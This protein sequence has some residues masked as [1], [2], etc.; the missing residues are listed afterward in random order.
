M[1]KSKYTGKMYKFTRGFVSGEKKTLYKGLKPS[2]I[3]FH[4]FE[5]LLTVIGGDCCRIQWTCL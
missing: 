1:A 2:S 5:A 3:N 4:Q